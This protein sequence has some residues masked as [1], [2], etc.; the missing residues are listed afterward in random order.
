MDADLR[1]D[2]AAPLRTF[3]LE[4]ALAVGAETVALVGP[5]GAGKTT[6]LRAV[7]GLHR[8]TRGRVELGGEVWFD[9]A[10]GVHLPP[11]E[12][13][14]GYVFQDYALFP[15]LSVAGNVAFGG[16]ARAG[17]LLERFRISHLARVRPGE[18]S[19][20][21]RQRVALARAL[22]RE[23]AVLLL[24]EPL[25]ALDADTRAH[26]RGELAGLLRELA[27]PT[28]VVTHDFAD[29]AV[30]AGRIAVLVD[31][32]IVQAGAAE[33]LIAAPTTGFV[34]SFTGA[35]VLRGRARPGPAGLTE[36]VLADGTRLL[37]ASAGRGTVALVV[38]PWDVSVA[39]EAP[40]D[41]MQNH[42]TGA[43]A[44]VAPVGNRARVTI[45]PLTAEVTA[46]SVERL[47][48]RP[49]TRAVASFKAVATRLL[50][51]D[52]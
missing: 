11:E 4:L 36:V 38:H 48:L 7:A 13:A 24:D 17:E 1:L 26:V 22:A 25:A 34:A 23:P 12:R 27:L 18:L 32:E 20:G 39:L 15:H 44:S 49:G 9:G 14:V 28:V 30:L 50:P 40:D 16:R 43:V 2:L 31:G 45:G 52:R 42:V 47:G 46:A 35:N 21:E 10:R 5:S 19:G 3:E 8:P 37:S 6:V 51:L 41:S 33:A 29:A